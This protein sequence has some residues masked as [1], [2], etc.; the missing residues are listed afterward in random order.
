MKSEN[1]EAPKKLAQLR[2]EYERISGAI[3]ALEALQEL[4]NRRARWTGTRQCGQAAAILQNLSQR[5]RVA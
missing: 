3:A 1:G 2:F 5:A 4:R